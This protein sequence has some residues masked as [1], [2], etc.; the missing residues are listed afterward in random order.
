MKERGIEE[1]VVQL[2]VDIQ[3]GTHCVV[4][5]SDEESS[6]FEVSTGVRQGCVMSPVLF[7]LVMD[8]IVCEALNKA[9]V[10]EVEIEYRKQGS[11]YMNYRVKA[12]ETSVIKAAM[13]ADDLTLIGKT[14]GELQKL[15]DSLHESCCKWGMKISIKKTK[16]L[17]I[18]CEQARILLD[19]SVL[20][21]VR[22]YLLGEYHEPR[23]WMHC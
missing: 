8:K 12:Q 2:I 19:D 3:D 17:S 10:G 20:E 18:G 6:K 5:S 21:N 16:V 23:W 1:Q 13:H 7:N 11:L 15:V 22:V 9:K 14:S 4:K